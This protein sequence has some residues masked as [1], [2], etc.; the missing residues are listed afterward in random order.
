MEEEEVGRKERE[1]RYPVE[2][3]LSGIDAGA[4]A[5]SP[6]TSTATSPLSKP[7]KRHEQVNWRLL[8]FAAS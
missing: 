3:P 7:N 8:N 5:V 2:T 4:V 1:G 6:N